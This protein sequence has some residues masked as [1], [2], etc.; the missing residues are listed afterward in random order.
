[1]K[2]LLTRLR[3]SLT[4]FAR[5]EEGMTLPLM[6]M[7]M[8]TL[9]TVTGVAIDVGRVQMAQSKL[10]FSL[11]A[12]GLA[13][14]STVSTTNLETEAAK[15]LNAN[16]NGYMGSIITGTSVTANT[17][18]T[19][20]DLG[21]T[22]S[23]PTTFMRVVGINDVT[24]SATSQI[25]RAV[26]GLELVMVLDNTGSMSETA[27][28]TTTK[29]AALK[30]AAN[31]LL[32]TL[33]G[34][35]DTIT[36]GKLWIGLVPFSQTVN[37]GT[38]HTSW[39]DATYDATITDWGPNGSW[40]GCVDAR[41]SGYDV[42]DT[43]PSQSNVNTLFRQ[44]YWLSDNLNPT[45]NAGRNQWKYITTNKKGVTTTTY[46]SPLTP[47][48][49]GPNYRCPQE[50]VSMTNAKSPLTTAINAM[51]AGGDTLINQGMVWGWSMLSPNWRGKWGGTMDSNSLP[52]DYHTKGMNKAV[53][54]L[55]DGVNT[56][57]NSAHGAYW[58]LNDNI[59]G[60]TNSTTAV[61]TL[62]TRTT[63]VCSAMKA[64]GIYIYVIALGTSFTTSTRTMLENCATSINYYF[65]APTTST[66][67]SVFTTIGDSLS[68]LRVSK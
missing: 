60:T 14:S 41:S 43:P 32:D 28:G 57:D 19:V 55:T 21:A 36:D 51:A 45:P 6:A 42:L 22:A 33:F 8:V 5:D 48:I 18:N 3:T 7:A 56:V 15:Y 54:L 2:G 26:T 46:D 65:E 66:L 49:Q 17:T 40:G 62:N 20:F 58:F 52:L 53:V 44:Y 11:D 4:R 24:I 27:G 61:T 13:A 37:I 38:S 50:V 9:T 23:V 30:T 31:T 59:L 63:N 10:L 1:M 47:T 64:K 39:M 68:N 34:S 16:F 35:K 67:T 25:T 12:A 29:L